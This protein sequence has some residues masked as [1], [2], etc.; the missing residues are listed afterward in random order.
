MGRP[1]VDPFEVIGKFARGIELL[2]VFQIFLTVPVLRLEQYAVKFVVAGIAE[3]VGPDG[4][5]TR[6][7]V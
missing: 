4:A 6:S 3:L 7:M 1:E 5:R 2:E